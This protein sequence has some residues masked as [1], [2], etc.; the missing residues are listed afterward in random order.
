MP[1][2]TGKSTGIQCWIN[3]PGRLKQVQPAYHQVD[4]HELPERSIEN[5]KIRVIV[6]G[7]SPVKLQTPVRYLDITLEDKGCYKEDIQEDFRGFVYVVNGVVV[8]ND[9]DTVAGDACF[10]DTTVDDTNILEI[11]SRGESRCMVLFGTPHHEPIIQHGP[12]VD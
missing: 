3:L 11:T 2:T 10:I 1:G 7:D 9:Q 6:G 8:I 4:A 12:F 5:G